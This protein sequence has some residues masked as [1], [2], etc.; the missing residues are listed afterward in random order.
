MVG[1]RWHSTGAR[2]IAELGVM[3]VV[4]ILALIVLGERV[5]PGRELG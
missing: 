2:A 1:A 5:A 3:S 4:A